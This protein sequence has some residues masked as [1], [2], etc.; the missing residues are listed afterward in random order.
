MLKFLYNKKRAR[1]AIRARRE[2]EEK[3]KGEF[4]IIFYEY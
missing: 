1:R 3:R 2:K 4:Y